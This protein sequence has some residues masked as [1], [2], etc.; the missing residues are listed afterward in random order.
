M[1]QEQVLATYQ[2]LQQYVGWADDDADRI[3][4]VATLLRPSFPALIDEFYAEILR[5]EET[6]AVLTGGEQQIRRLKRSL[7]DWLSQLLAG[8]YDQRYVARRWAVGLRHVDIGV[9]SVFVNVSLARLRLGLCEYLIKHW[10]D[11][12]ATL[13]ATLG[14]LHK[15]LDLDLAV[16]EHAYHS[17]NLGR[18]RR[19]IDTGRRQQAAV[20]FIG[21][22]AL[23]GGDL[24]GLMNETV[25]IVADTLRVELCKVL[26]LSSEG[27]RLVL[28]AGH[29]WPADAIGSA[30]VGSEPTTQAGYTLQQKS[31]VV[32]EDFA[33]ET[34]FQL[35]PILA[36]RGVV[37]GMSVLIHGDEQPY[38][39]LGAHATHPTKFEQSDVDFLQSVA[40]VVA[41]AI[42]R[43]DVEQRVLQSERLAAIGQM[44]AGLAHESRNALQ[45]SQAC[46]EMLELELADNPDAMEMIVRSQRAQQHLNRLFE[47]VRGYAAP[48]VLDRGEADVA[49]IWREAWDYLAAQ[50]EGRDAVLIE[51]LGRANRRCE[52]DHFQLIQVFRNVFENAL[53]ACED[54][55][56]IVVRCDAEQVGERRGLRISI[57]DNGPGMNEEQHRRVFEPFYTTKTKGTGLGMAI[58]ERIVEAHG[59]AIRI[60]SSDLG[61][62]VVITLPRKERDPAHD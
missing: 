33:H 45:R 35:P 53:S 51:R 40:N 50:R 6:R 48:M 56:E 7:R 36:E 22:R 28:K 19:A 42:R 30:A 44:I 59:G 23:Q 38:G 46:L 3:A 54:P 41:E 10:E 20:A 15:L 4:A 14:S 61:A 16:I 37:S 9:P 31:P 2:Q 49:E 32:V 47:E 18:V 57:R 60:G 17:E 8:E 55:T 29:G 11:D 24:P 26:E 43:K 27:D 1:S 5:H 13:Q 39:V 21:R 58:S 34:R 25:R 52:V 12:Q 62:E